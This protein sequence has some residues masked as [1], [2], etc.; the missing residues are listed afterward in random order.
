MLH[1]KRLVGREGLMYIRRA[2][3]ERLKDAYIEYE[4]EGYSPH[5]LA[6]SLRDAVEFILD[7]AGMLEECKQ[8]NIP[9]VV[10]YSEKQRLDMLSLGFI[11]NAINVHLNALQA[12]EHE[13][14][15]ERHMD[16]IVRLI[17]KYR[18]AEERRNTL[19]RFEIY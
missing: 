18:E 11:E 6:N 19:C 5:Y 10:P 8:A 3:L 9:T 1:D 2:N 14:M 17:S 4:L 15:D 12:E 16:E 7:D 13:E